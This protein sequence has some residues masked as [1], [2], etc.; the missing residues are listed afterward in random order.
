VGVVPVPD[1]TRKTPT[2]PEPYPRV[3][4]G[5]GIPAGTGRPA[6]LYRVHTAVYEPCTR[7]VHTAV[8]RLCTRRFTGRA[9]G[10]VRVY[11]GR[12]HVPV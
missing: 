9:D 5:S 2:R 11:T 7:F 12:V 4:V 10:R 6:H 3:R 8:W 1:P